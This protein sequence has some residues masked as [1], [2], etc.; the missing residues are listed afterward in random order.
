MLFVPRLSFLPVGTQKLP[1]TKNDKKEIR[2]ATTIKNKNHIL[3]SNSM[4]DPRGGNFD[5]FT[6][7][8]VNTGY[9]LSLTCQACQIK[10]FSYYK[11]VEPPKIVLFKN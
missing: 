7:E 10:K 2:L 8:W 3:V 9:V 11:Q 6:Y 4:L 1:V 5:P